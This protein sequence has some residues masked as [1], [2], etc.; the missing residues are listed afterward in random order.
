MGYWNGTEKFFKFMAKKYFPKK[1]ILTAGPSISAKEVKYV[2]DAVKNGWNEKYDYY[3]QRF[4]EEFAKYVGVKYA[5]PTSSGTGA[6]HAALLA[7]DIKKGDEVIIPEIT[8]VASAN[9]VEFVGATPVFVDVEKDTWTIDVKDVERKITS[10][11]KAIMPVHIYG[12]VSDMK[13]INKIAKKHNL[14]V[15]EDACPSL[16][17]EYYGKK[18][19]SLSDVAALSLRAATI[20]VTGEGGM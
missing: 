17:A 7:L 16:G 1:T 15:I 5:W 2:L 18:T 19:G 3:I 6:L 8:F 14:Y 13:G 9:V 20:S 10:K 12:N 4:S 11:T